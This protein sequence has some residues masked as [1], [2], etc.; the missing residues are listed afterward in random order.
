MCVCYLY[1]LV[2]SGYNFL[3]LTVNPKPAPFTCQLLSRGFVA[4]RGQGGQAR[5]LFEDALAMAQWSRQP[6]GGGKCR[7]K[8]KKWDFNGIS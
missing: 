6:K 2:D 4:S 1:I 3:L 7:G 5:E 8:K